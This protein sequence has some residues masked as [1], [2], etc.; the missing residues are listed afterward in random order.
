VTELARH[1][2]ENTLS[3]ANQ[4]WQSIHL[5]SVMHLTETDRS[6]G[7]WPCVWRLIMMAWP[8]DVRVAARHN[9]ATRRRST[10]CGGTPLG[11]V[12]PA[13]ADRGPGMCA[14]VR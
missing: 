13:K 1:S 4:D 10:G 7:V 2:S 6:S 5:S 8:A 3:K 14:R 12:R 11:S 9:T